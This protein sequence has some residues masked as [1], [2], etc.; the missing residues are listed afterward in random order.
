M[1]FL[2]EMAIDLILFVLYNKEEIFFKC[3]GVGINGKK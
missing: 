2:K 3:K 1:A